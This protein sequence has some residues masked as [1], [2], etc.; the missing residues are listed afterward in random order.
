MDGVEYDDYGN[1]EEEFSERF[2]VYFGLTS[3]QVTPIDRLITVTYFAFTTLSTVG[4]GDYHPRS[5][6]ERAYCAFILLFGVAIF[7]LVMGKFT[8][9]VEE[10][11]DFN[12]EIDYGDE[13]SRFF[14]LLCKYNNQL[15]IDLSLKRKIESHF[16][17]K[18]QKDKNQCLESPD[19]Q[20]M[21]D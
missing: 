10:F 20:M 6:K 21:F 12:K 4:F 2:L 7:S 14:G 1:T 5:D 8:E 3:K 15:P 19:D 11:K 17:Y 16:E 9:I 18:W 13:L